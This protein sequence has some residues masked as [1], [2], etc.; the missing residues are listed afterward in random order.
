MQRVLKGTY[1]TRRML[2]WL[3]VGGMVSL[4]YLR[5]L[6]QSDAVPVIAPRALRA[7]EGQSGKFEFEVASVRPNEKWKYTDPGYSLDSDDDYKPSQGLFIADAPLSTFIA[8][9]YKLD[10]QHSMIANLPKW[11]NSQSYEIRARVPGTPMKDQVRLMMQ[12][13]LADR[14]KLAIHFDKQEKPALGLVFIKPGK[15]GPWLHLHGEDGCKVSGTPPKLDGK[16]EGLDWLPCGVYIALDRPE[17]ALFAAARNTTMRQLCAFLS[18]VGGLG[19]TVV[20]Q[21]GIIENIDFGVEYTKP[22]TD[23]ASDVASSLGESLV[24]ALNDQLG[25]K[26]V[27]V[28][29]LLDIPLVDRVEMPSEN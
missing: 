20:D 11:A 14:F 15:F 8:F 19:R 2:L 16:A 1:A 18:N 27:P 10:M 28:K 7:A 6:G 12:A 21:T 4:P 25:L 22:K 9:A 17:G 26:L 23:A 13:L 29:A 24:S 3:L 5:I